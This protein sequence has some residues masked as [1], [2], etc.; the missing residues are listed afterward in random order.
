MSRA[1]LQL[2]TIDQWMRTDEATRTFILKNIKLK[3]RLYRYLYEANRHGDKSVKDAHWVKCSRCVDSPYPGFILK[4]PRYDGLHP[5]EMGHPCL[6]RIYNS[7]IGTEGVERIEP[8]TRLIFDLGHAV[9]HMFQTYG[10]NG[11]WGDI[12]QPEVEINEARQDVAKDLLLEGHADAENIL[13][14]DESGYPLIEIGL[15]HEYKSINDANFKKL[16]TAKPEHKQQ[17]TLYSAAL[18]RP[19]AVYLY[20]NKND[21]NISDFPIQFNPDVWRKLYEKAMVLRQLYNSKQPPKGDVGF[22]CRDC[23]Y[24]ENCSDYHA[25]Q[26]RRT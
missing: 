20:L 4:E 8:R 3:D 1:T 26:P 6:L 12:Y 7:M 19:V 18:N 22:H 21:S 25:A 2:H 23:P 9:H 11:A 24:M 16:T 13:T 5:S 14:I 17:A 15:V 10:L